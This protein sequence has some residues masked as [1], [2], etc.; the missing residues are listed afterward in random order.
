MSRIIAGTARGHRVA[1]PRG[2]ATR[3]TT[4]RVREA[5]F[6]ALVSAI[7]PLDGVP[8]LDLY[9]GSGAVGLEAA[10]RGAAPV[11]C[12]ESDRPT[13]DL[14][15]AN[16]R[17]LGLDA[18]RVVASRVERLPEGVEPASVLRPRGD[19]CAGAPDGG[20]VTP[21]PFQVAFADPPYT[22]TTAA[23][24]ETLAALRGSGWLASGATVVVERPRRSDAVGAWEW[25]VGWEGV[26]DKRY[27]ETMLWYGRAA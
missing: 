23:L 7:G 21:A 26:R 15:R 24:R 8:F 9:A 27:G 18:V 17:R 2:S 13:A 10:S 20:P 25:P 19:R 3:P 16:V 5:L 11:L 12:V 4:D 6:S 22:L 1:A 14:I